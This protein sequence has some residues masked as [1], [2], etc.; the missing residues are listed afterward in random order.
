MGLYYKPKYRLST[1]ESQRFHD[2][3]SVPAWF[4]AGRVL[5][6]NS[7]M[8]YLSASLAALLFAVSVP[9]GKA[10]LAHMG[11]LEL[12][13]LCY[14]GSGLGL[15]SWRLFSGRGAEA[16]LERR[17]LPFAAGF[18]AAGGVLAPLLLFTG[19]AHTT[20]SSASM[21]LNSEL[22]FTSLIAVL[23]FKEQG[24]WRLWLAA[25]LITAG[26]VVLSWEGGGA[27][28]WGA[29]LVLGAALMWGIDNN[30]TARISLKDPVAIGAIKGLAGGLINGALALASPG[31]MPS[32][33]WAA[34]A[35]LLGA[36]SYG[37]SLV[38]FILAMRGLGASRAGAFFGAYPFIGAA[39]GVAVLGEP[40]GWRLA[41]SGALMLPAFLVLALE[42]HSHRHSHEALEHEHSH[43]HDDPHHGHAHD[44]APA[45]P[46]SHPH[47]HEE[48]A[49]E[50][51]HMP[52]SHHRHAH[53]RI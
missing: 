26:G 8:E 11:P 32:A 23:V 12:S 18:A 39:L 1:H 34:T 14:L 25:A 53:R 19:L 9:A 2:E 27:L 6:Y 10:L 49:H 7:G 35:L 4:G 48:L 15:L 52:D 24:G 40:F 16:R 20:S 28:D 31:G 41:V 37:V 50:H 43:T 45:G 29:G 38:L 17:D 46:H 36:F 30:L 5:R 21:L 13:S 22:V 3:K 44:G 47:R 42:S 51:A 33:G